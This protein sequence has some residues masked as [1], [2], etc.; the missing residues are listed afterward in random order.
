MNRD[1]KNLLTSRISITLTRFLY[2]F[3]LLFFIVFLFLMVL[4]NVEFILYGP[5]SANIHFLG[6][7][8]N[9][10]SFSFIL[11]E[12]CFTILIL[13]VIYW[14]LL[15]LFQSKSIYLDKKGLSFKTEKIDWRDI[16][17]IKIYPGNLPRFVCY[18]VKEGNE[19][20]VIGLFPLFSDMQRDL[21]IS[22]AD[23]NGICTKK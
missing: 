23:K 21:L 7:K 20:K 18:Y 19:K 3:V 22:A 17:K 11:F 5:D 14:V 4:S 12:F 6:S 2:S 1:S 16:V 9:N 13:V 15:L 8:L 10:L